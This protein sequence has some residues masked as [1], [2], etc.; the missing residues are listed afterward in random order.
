MNRRSE[1][2]ADRIQR[3][4]VE[5]VVRAALIGL[6]LLG[7]AWGIL[8]VLDRPKS[9]LFSVAVW[10]AVPAVLSDL[11]LLPVVALVGW[12]LTRWLPSW[13]RLPAQVALTVI[14][15][16]TVIALPFL[17][18][19]GVRPDNPTLLNRDYPLGLAV[20]AGVVVIAAV[21]WAIARRYR[22]S[23]NKR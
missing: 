20:Y 16:L 11:L 5:S 22:L 1:V 21:C 14:G 13:A 15:L 6:G 3:H 10:F 7:I 8:L 23:T 17:G 4:P 9:E 2:M 19:P 18:T 12:A